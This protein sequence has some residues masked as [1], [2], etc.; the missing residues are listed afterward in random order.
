MKKGDLISV[1]DET[2]KGTI[3]SIGKDFAIIED[4][5]GFEH[6]I[7]I[8]KIIPR[9]SNL[10]EKSKVLIKDNLEKKSS[11]KNSD[12]VRNIDLHFEKLVKNTAE[13]SAFERLQIQKETLIDN[14]DYCKKN[15][16]KKLNVIHGI[17]DGILQNLVYDYLKGYV[18]IQYEED[19]F[20][21]HSSGN[22]L[23]TF[24]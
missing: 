10:Y 19:D 21:F 14:L 9:E 15:Y 5:F 23:V 2:T 8:S 22:V 6:S 1:L 3:I 13:Y 7:E 20:F 12:N 24:L 4:E 18:G 17:G 11:K 16:I